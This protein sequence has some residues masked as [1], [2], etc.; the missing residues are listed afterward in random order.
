[1][2]MSLAPHLKK[3]NHTHTHTG[4]QVT[5]RHSERQREPRQGAE[6]HQHQQ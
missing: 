3:K 2:E 5:Y 4:K 1:L 6:D